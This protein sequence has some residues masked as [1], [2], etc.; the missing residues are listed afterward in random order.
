MA[1]SPTSVGLALFAGILTV[2]SPCILPVLPIIMG[3]SLQSHRYAPLILVMGLISGFALTGSL[4]G[5]ASSWVTGIANALRGVAIA[6]LLGMGL[7]ALFPQ[8]LSSGSCGHL[9]R[10]LCWEVF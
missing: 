7:L 1:G 8:E 2:L 10:G 9:A 6:F 4:L 3:R 5:I